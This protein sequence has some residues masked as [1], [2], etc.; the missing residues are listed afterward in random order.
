MRKIIK[1]ER[2]KRGCKYCLDYKKDKCKH[3]ECP[4]H[5]LDNYA[6]YEKFFK[7]QEKKCPISE[8]LKL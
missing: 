3:A 8:I 1:K 2:K 7:D 4:Y 5:E 6:T